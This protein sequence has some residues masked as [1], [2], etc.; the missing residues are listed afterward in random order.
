MDRAVGALDAMTNDS[1]TIGAKRPSA[2]VGI[3]AMTGSATN[4]S[5]SAC[6]A[7]YMMRTSVSILE[8]FS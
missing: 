7:K 8:T 1:P 4:V 2:T 5:T 6:V 3:A